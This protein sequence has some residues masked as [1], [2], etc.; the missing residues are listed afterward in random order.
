MK[1]LDGKVAFITGGGSGVALGQA[2]VFAE[3]AG[4]KMVIADVRQDHLDE[5]MAYFKTRN[6][7]VHAI[8]LDITDREAFARAADEAEKVFGPVQLLCNTAG[9]SQFGPVE[10]ATFDDWDWQIDVNLKGMINGVQT[11]MPRMIER[12]QGGHIVNT[13]SMSAFVALPTTA[14]YCT[15]KYAVRGLSESL[16]IELGKYDIGVSCL[17]PGAVNTNIDKSVEARPEK[18][19]KTGYYGADPEVFAR[20][21]AV[22]EG[23]FDPV[24]LGRIVMEAVRRNDFW[25]LPYPEF[26]PTIENSTAEVVAA[27]KQYESHPDYARRMKLRE[28]QGR[29]MPGAR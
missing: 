14:I 27:L 12:G 25:I 15:T 23:G 22:I 13:A 26:V 5:A 11:F 21:K 24:D 9:V 28:Q 2:K 18:Y 29:P 17:C 20:L 3:E 6:V 8:R 7:P 1:D 10:K 16:R 4:M 19:G